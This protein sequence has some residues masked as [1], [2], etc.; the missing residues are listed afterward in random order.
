MGLFDMFG[1]NPEREA[2]KEEDFRCD[3]PPYLSREG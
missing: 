1:S 2:Q 3:R